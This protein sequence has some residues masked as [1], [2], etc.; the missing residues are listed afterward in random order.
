MKISA[1]DPGARFKLPYCGKVGELVRVGTGAAVV[2]YDNDDA[3]VEVTD[4]RTGETKTFFRR[5]RPVL[6]S[7]STEVVPA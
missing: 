1:M 6:I 4:G 3:D 2:R 5:G 7:A